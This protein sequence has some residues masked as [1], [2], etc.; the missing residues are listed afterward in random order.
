MAIAV[1]YTVHGDGGTLDKYFRVIEMMG[2]R[3]EGTHPDPDCLFHWVTE[4]DDGGYKVTDV[5]KNRGAFEAFAENQIKP[6]SAQLG[7]PAGEAK[8]LEVDN[9]LT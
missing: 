5:W 3:P 9:Y 7:I 6:A 8:F 2:T 1:E 4:L